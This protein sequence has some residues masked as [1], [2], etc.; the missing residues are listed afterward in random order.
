MLK[1]PEW[2]IVLNYAFFDTYIQSE[3]YLHTFPLKRIWELAEHLLLVK[4][5][6]DHIRWMGEAEKCSHWKLHP[7]PGGTCRKGP[8]EMGASPRGTRG[9]CLIRHTSSLDLPWKDEPLNIRLRKPM[10]LMSKGPKLISATETLLL[11][12]S[13][14]MSFALRC[15]E[16]VAVWKVPGLYVMESHL[17]T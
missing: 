5:K 7:Y 17:R 2:H 6:K 8:H 14:V 3:K 4:N 9:W 10:G 12:V 13:H 16:I 11:K 1:T 15:G